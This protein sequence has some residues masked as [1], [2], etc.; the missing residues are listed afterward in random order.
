MTDASMHNQVPAKEQVDQLLDGWMEAG[1]HLYPIMVQY[2]DTDLAGNVFH[3]QYI[4]YAER[5]RSA[6]IRHTGID[7]RQMRAED[8]AFTVRRIAIDYRAPSWLGEKL[9]VRTSLRK[10]GGALLALDQ[11][12]EDPD[13]GIRASMVVD[14]ALISLATGVLRLPPDMRDRIAATIA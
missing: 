1:S 14:I 13:G 6:M 9:L 8:Q 10:L 5:G 11:S 12:I 2:E 3:G 7:Q 4:A